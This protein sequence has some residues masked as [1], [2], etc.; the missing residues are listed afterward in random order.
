MIENMP[1]RQTSS[2]PSS[3]AVQQ[4]VR[5]DVQVVGRTCSQEDRRRPGTAGGSGRMGR[6][7]NGR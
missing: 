1:G 7:S 5:Y 6:H 4:S 3:Q 2:I